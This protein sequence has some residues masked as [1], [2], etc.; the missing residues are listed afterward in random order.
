VNDNTETQPVQRKREQSLSPDGKWRSF[1]QV[2]NLLQ[3]VSNA[4]HY[5]RIKVKGK[6]IHES[7]REDFKG[8]QKCASK[9]G[10]DY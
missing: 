5:G 3:Y 6:L 2:P 9:G 10:R 1:P 8:E 4:N 7:C